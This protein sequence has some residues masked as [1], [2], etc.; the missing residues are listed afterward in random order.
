MTFS[1]RVTSVSHM[2]GLLI[3]FEGRSP[4]LGDVLRING[5]KLLGKVDTVLGPV[6]SGLVHVH[7]LFNNVDASRAV[8]SP[9]E[10]KVYLYMDVA[11][12]S[13]VL[14]ATADADLIIDG[15]RSF[16]YSLASA[17]LNGDGLDD[18]LIGAPDVDGPQELYQDAGTLYDRGDGGNGGRVYIYSGSSLSVGATL[19]QS[20]AD[21][22]I[23]TSDDFF[24]GI[25]VLTGD[26]NDDGNPDIFVSEPM[27]ESGNGNQEGAVYYFVSP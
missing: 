1:G 25:D 22:R 3:S 8:G 26:M 11:S 20:N 9:V 21:G 14:D 18:L 7:P 4:N 5:G 16:G 27:W 19:D 2:G 12:L 23:G 17:D 15:D 6:D 10:N 13:G 24:F